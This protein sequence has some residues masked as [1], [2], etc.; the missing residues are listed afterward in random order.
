MK[1]RTLTLLA[2]LV[3]LVAAYF[4]F[5]HRWHGPDNEFHLLDRNAVARIQLEQV[6]AAE[7][8]AGLLLERG[9]DGE[10]TVNGRHAVSEF[11]IRD[12]LKLL[13]DIRVKEPI[14]GKAQATSLGLL[15]RNHLRVRIWDED[16]NQLKDYLV[17]PTNNAQTANIYKMAFSDRCYMVTRPATEGYVS[18]YY[19][20]DETNWRDLA[21]WNI[22][23][24]ELKLVEAEYPTDSMDQ[25]F[26]LRLD[27]AGWRMKDGTAPDSSRVSAYLSLFSGKIFAES[28][29]DEKYPGRMDSLIHRTPDARFTLE[30]K[31]GKRI[32]LLLFSR[33]ESNANLFAYLDQTKDLLTVQHYVIDPFLKTKG[34]FGGAPLEPKQP[35]P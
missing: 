33:P 1:T 20:L 25:G 15:K 34:F 21:L 31:S 17:G 22:Q 35:R 19:S 29:A 14:I 12:F 13:G 9:K 27:G 6:N 8:D 30:T 28:Y 5:V 32:S 3:A 26:S 11:K 24:D 2:I 16:G 7:V 4:A 18:I 23:R 10:W